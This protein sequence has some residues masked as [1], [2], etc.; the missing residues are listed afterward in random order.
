M[1]DPVPI[2]AKIPPPYRELL[3][4]YTTLLN[5]ERRRR[6][7]RPVSSAAVAGAL[8]C[9]ILDHHQQDILDGYEA[10]RTDAFSKKFASF[11]G[12]DLTAGAS[13]VSDP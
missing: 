8:L 12:G 6:G 2:R 1:N 10:Q 11:L 13:D 9:F 5:T 7:Q 3:R 4:R